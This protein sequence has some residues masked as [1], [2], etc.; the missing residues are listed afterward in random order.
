MHV[1]VGRELPPVQWVDRLFYRVIVGSGQGCRHRKIAPTVHREKL[2]TRQELTRQLPELCRGHVSPHVKIGQSKI[3]DHFAG[4]H[5]LEFREVETSGM[6]SRIC[7]RCNFSSWSKQDNN[8]RGAETIGTYFDS[9]TYSRARTV[10]GETVP[11]ST[12]RDLSI[13]FSPSSMCSLIETQQHNH[14]FWRID[15]RA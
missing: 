14:V 10:N 11:T 5:R 13:Y 9:V 15:R 2:Q 12:A 1:A 8:A 3:S 6:K 4:L 7:R